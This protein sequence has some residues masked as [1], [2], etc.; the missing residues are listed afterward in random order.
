[1]ADHLLVV[2]GGLFSTLQDFGRFGYQRFGIS[3]SGAM[4]T[5]AMRIANALVGNAPGAAVVEMTMLGLAATVEAEG[6]R[7]A[8]AGADFVIAINGRPAEAWRS[9]DLARGDRLEVGAA[10]SGMR[11]YLAVAGGFAL[12]PT[13]GSLSTH[14]RSGIGGLDGRALQ[15]GDRLPLHHPAPS[16][17]LLVLDAAD[18]PRTD[19]PIRVV[20]GPQ[21]DAFTPAGIET[22]L[23]SAYRVTEKA[24]R[25]GCRLDG[26]V[27]EHARGFNIVSDGIMNGSIQVPGQ[28]T[29]IVLLADRQSTGGYPKIATVIGPDL[30]RLGQRRPDDEIRFRRVTIDEAEAI[31]AEHAGAM[32]AIPSRLRPVVDAAASLTSE[33]LLSANLVSGVVLA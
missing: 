6:C 29:P 20:L 11:G 15:A 25:M 18:R 30:H 9:H 17:P 5:V 32:R 22:F 28:G 21:Q 7:V 31:A 4:D 33:R 8:V 27:I 3:A 12:A 1:M 2:R 14:S 10:R 23:A 24:D 13:L 19:G 26:P 16:G